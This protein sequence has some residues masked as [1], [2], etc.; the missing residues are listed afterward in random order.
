MK[1]CVCSAP[2]QSTSDT[3]NSKNAFLFLVSLN[4][5]RGQP[6]FRICSW[7]CIERMARKLY[8]I[9][10][11][12]IRN[13]LYGPFSSKLHTLKRWICHI[14]FRVGIRWREIQ[15]SRI[16]VT[17]ALQGKQ[18]QILMLWWLKNLW[19]KLASQLIRFMDVTQNCAF[20]PSLWIFLRSSKPTLDSGQPAKP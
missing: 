7:F 15:L 4:W 10:T 11:I 1:W 18:D 6:N 16:L 19:V 5:Q 3:D 2:N 9:I 13:R 20:S 12:T 8:E 14:F 17:F